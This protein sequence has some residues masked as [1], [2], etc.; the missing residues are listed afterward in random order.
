M[1]KGLGGKVDTMKTQ[2]VSLL[3]SGGSSTPAAYRYANQEKEKLA[4]ELFL[5]PPTIQLNLSLFLLSFFD[6]SEVFLSL[7]LT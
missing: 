6:I 1:C 2:T 5:S 4:L 3:L 7:F